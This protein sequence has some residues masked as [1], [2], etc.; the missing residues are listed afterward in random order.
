MTVWDRRSGRTYLVD[1][2]ADF[3]VFPASPAEKRSL[4]PSGPLVAANGSLIKTWGKKERSLLLGQGRSFVQEF[5]VADVS[6][7]ILGADFFINN[8]LAI[9]MAGRRLID[10]AD[11]ATIPTKITCQQPSISGIHAPSVNTFDRI[12]DEFPELLIP[13]FK[14]TDTNKHG[15]EHHI[16]TKGPPL[17]ARARRLDAD[18]L[19]VAKSEFAEME[20]LGIIRRSNSPWASPLHIVRKPNGG[21][22]PCGD[23]RRLNNAT[24]DDRY[25]LPHIQ[26]FNANLAGKTVFSKVDLVRG[27]HQIPMAPNDIAKTAI[28]TP[29]GLWEFLR[30]PFGL[31]NAAQAFQRLMD[32]ILRGIPSVFVYLDDILV[33]SANPKEHTNHLRQVFQLLSTNGLVVNRAKSVFGVSKLTYLGHCVDATGI[34]P[35]PSRVDAVSD[36]PVPDSKASLQRFLGMINFYHR[37]LPQLAE[38]LHP[39]HEATKTKGQTITWTPECQ[40]AFESAKSALAAAT[41]LHHPHPTART[42]ITTDASEKAVGGQLEQFQAGVWLPIAFFSRKLSNAE[43]KYSAFDRE[44]LAIYLAIKHFR[45]L[46]EGRAFTIYTDHKPLTFAFASATERSP[47]QTRHLSFIAEFSTDVRHI[48]GKENIVA[49]TLSRADLSA[50]S[51]P[52]I[53]YRRLAADQACSKE[54]AAYKTSITS[55]RFADVPFGDF[56]VLCDV[57]TGRNRPV[58]PSEWT[59]R[60]FETIHGLSHPG[61][62]PT[63]RAVSSRFVWHGLKRDIRRWC[64]E[65]HACQSSKIQRHIH[66]PIVKRDPPDR[67]FGSIHVDIVG[68]LPT[69]ESKTYLFTIVDRFTRWPEVI[70]MRDCTTETCAKALIRHWIARFGVPESLTSDRGPQFTS[71]LWTALNKLWGISASTTTAYHPQANGMVERLHRQLKT[72]LKARLSGPNWMDELPLVLL[73][74]RTAWREDAGC[75]A[76]DLVYGTG[77]HVPGEFFPPT[78]VRA[79]GSTP[80]TEFLRHLQ[81]MMRSTL[82][83]PPQ[84]HGKHPNYKPHN[85]AATGFVY[86]RHDA[87]RGPLQRPYSGPFKILEAAGK[88]FILDVNGRRDKVSIDRLKVAYGQTD[89]PAP[90]TPTHPHPVPPTSPTPSTDAKTPLPT[91]SFGRPIKIPQRFR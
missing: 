6:E 32:G 35:M 12:I 26:D 76:A 80:P 19:E 52:T 66:A 29:F 4:S 58:V 22:R 33:A 64:R 56:T 46:V 69:S 30:M 90:S 24:V 2:G 75:S 89:T 54:I 53:D 39:L 14:P 15:V 65:C 3:S 5:Q 85:L 74:I 41:L 31:K 18:K 43:K 51:L 78:E 59:R 82:P 73:G 27:Y 49:D 17:H 42:N 36:F 23:F 72:S 13:R 25:P 20:R 71:H 1:C 10:M 9:D 86:V 21:W 34:S 77:L 81:N 8:N 11:L 16:I 60:I 45:H 48:T 28:I 79:Q 7:P 83:P 50:V 87:H 88:Y 38:K 68:P 61:Y 91:S 40:V 70:P 44:L 67:R 37:F 62:K 84:F 47:R 57:S 63:Q 55:L